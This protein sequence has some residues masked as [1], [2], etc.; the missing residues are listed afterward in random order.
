MP[1]FVDH[2]ENKIILM[3]ST[4]YTVAKYGFEGLT[5][6]D[7]SKE[8]NM[9]EA[10]IYRYFLDKTDLLV[11]AFLY[12]DE[13]L[14][15]KLTDTLK[16][17]DNI[18]YSLE[19]RSKMYFKEMWDF[20]LSDMNYSKFYIRFYYSSYLTDSV[21]KIHNELCFKYFNKIS[22]YLKK[23]TNQEVLMHH[24]FSSLLTFI[25]LIGINVIENNDENFN[26]IFKIIN[27]PLK[28]A[29]DKNIIS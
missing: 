2:N 22:K 8:C 24:I 26:A 12:T 15:N 1:K 16:T 5:I 27:D 25:N 23:G 18:E 13:E 19:D 29:L 20:F 21:S 28:E 7:I 11:Q 14:F 10:Y 6:K 4:I 17:F 3:K 9:N